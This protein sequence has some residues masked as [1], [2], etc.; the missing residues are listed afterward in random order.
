MLMYAKQFICIL[1]FLLLISLW[2]CKTQKKTIA[3]PNETNKTLID[4]TDCIDQSQLAKQAKTVCNTTILPVCGCDG[5]TYRNPCE[6]KKKGLITYKSGRCAGDKTD[7]NAKKATPA[8]PS[9]GSTSK[10]CIDRT[11]INLKAECPTIYEPVCGC[12]G[13]N[14]S[15]ECEAKRKGLT[16]FT[17]GEC[18]R[19]NAKNCIDKTR[20]RP[21]ATCQ[22][23][24][25]PVCGCDGKTYTNACEAKKKGLNYFKNGTCGDTSSKNGKESVPTTSNACIDNSKINPTAPCTKQYEPVCGCDGKTYDNPC[26]AKKNGLRA[27]APGPCQ[28]DLSNRPE[29]YSIGTDCIDPI[30]IKKNVMCASVYDPVCGCDG[31]TYSNSCVATR[32]GVVSFEKGECK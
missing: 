15:N 8:P 21:N 24:V 4:G 12:D 7:F 9:D 3:D 18:K 10:Y 30:K 23:I 31:K 14:Y 32:N 25:A 2:A 28:K 27:F 6:A 11:K 29:T 5:K 1:G 20:I 16:R 19:P 26:M 17:P 13:K 22:D